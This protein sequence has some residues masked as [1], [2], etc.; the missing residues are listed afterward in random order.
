MAIDSHQLVDLVNRYRAMIQADTETADD[1]AAVA[2]FLLLTF[3]LD[4]KED[5]TDIGE[6]VRTYMLTVAGQVVDQAREIGFSL[7][8]GTLNG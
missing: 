5:R 8:E 4:H 3:A 6:D 1:G 7:Q 2:A